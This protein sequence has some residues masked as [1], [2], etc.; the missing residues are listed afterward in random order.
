MSQSG[1]LAKWGG[2]LIKGPANGPLFTSVE[3]KF[4]VPKVTAP[5]GGPK[6]HGADFWVGFDGHKTTNP[7]AILQAGVGVDI[8]FNG[9][10]VA[11]CS[12]WMEWYPD[13]KQFLDDETH[14]IDYGDEVHIKVTAISTTDGEVYVHN[15][16]KGYQITK[17]IS[18]SVS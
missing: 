12:L 13:A 9:D 4:K 14:P 8:G 11:D 10:G 16:T 3:A 2:V 5:K 7:D 17:P 1:H 6:V 15:L 18:G